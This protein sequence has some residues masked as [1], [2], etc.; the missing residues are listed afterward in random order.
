MNKKLTR[1]NVQNYQRTH[2]RMDKKDN[3]KMDKIPK[4]QTPE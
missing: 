1:E 3:M 2:P 4:G